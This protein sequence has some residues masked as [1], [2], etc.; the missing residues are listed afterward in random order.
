MRRTLT[1]FSPRTAAVSGLIF[2]LLL[3]LFFTPAYGQYFGRNKVQYEKFDYQ[4]LKTEHF[5]IYFYPEEA[6][7]VRVAAQMAE[8]WYK[9]FSRLLSHELRGRQ[10]LIMYASHPQF[11]QTTVLP[12]ILSEGTGGVTESAKRRIILPFG[13]TLADTDHVIG[14]EL[15]HAFQYDMASAVGPR[16]ANAQNGG[17]LERAPLWFIEG[18]AEYFS[19]GPVDSLTAMWMRDMIRKK[20]IPTI[21]DLRNPYKYFPYRYGQALWA[22]IGGRYGDLTVAK[23]MRDVCRGIDYEV[24]LEKTLNIKLDQ[25][26]KDWQEALKKDYN[27]ILAVTQAPAKLGRLVARG[28]ET[29]PYNVAPV[30]SPDGKTF[31]FISSHDLFSIEM[32]MG[33][34]KTGKITRKITKTAVDSHFQSIQ[35]INSAGSWNADGSRFVFGAVSEGKPV[36]AFLDG[37]GR[38]IVD[39]IKFPAL[40]EILNP[41]FAPDGKRIAFSA[42]TGGYTD[43]YLYDLDTKTLQNMTDDAFGDVHPAWSPDGRWVV[44]VTERYSSQLAT[45]GMIIG[46]YDLALLDTATGDIKKFDVLPGARKINPQWASDSKSIFFVSDRNGISNIYRADLGTRAVAMVTNLYTGISGISN[47]SPSISVASRTNDLFYSAYDDGSYSIYSLE[48]KELQVGTPVP[49]APES[50]LAAVL[51]PKDRQGSEILGLIKNAG[52]GLPDSSKFSTAPYKPKLSLDYVIPPTVGVGYDPYYGAYGGGGIAAYWSDMMGWHNLMTMANVSSRLMDSQA[53]V[54][55]QNSKNRVNFGGVI[56]R[57]PLIY[58]NYA[59]SFDG[60]NY[61]EQE[62]LYRQIYYQVGGFANYPFS[63]FSRFELSAG[64]TYI[65]FN[66]VVYTSVYDYYTGQPLVVDERTDLPSPPGIHMGYL[67][68]ALV[69]D[70]SLFGATAPILGQSYRV[71]VSPSFGT[72]NY[73][74]VTADFRKYLVPVKPFTLAFRVMH[75]G[76]YGKGAEDPRLWPMFLGY[77]MLVR[78]YDYGS[79]TA[80]EAT[81]GGFDMNRLFGS[82]VAIANLELRFPLFGLLGLGKGFYGIFPLDVVGFYDMGLAWDNVNKPWF[83][84]GGNPNWKPVTSAGVGVRVNLFGYIVLGVSY[85]KPFDRKDAAG[86]SIPA[87]FQFSFYPGF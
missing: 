72:L 77:E 34:S 27:P 66:N 23:L 20:K 86:K 55:Y 26:S 14:H 33:D 54:A 37:E 2:G 78:G 3:S 13:G 68:A 41:S 1:R 17:G 85:V 38:K 69:Y 65:Q 39:E 64:Y 61:I 56:Q 70:S 22:Y 36:L 4:V 57:M 44:F 81:T 48:P 67:G 84:S 62:I 83:V 40:G 19:I 12:D 63:P 45:N 46:T 18:L 76:R 5:D 59:A 53:L 79:F 10:P 28:T 32:F 52:Y 25:L 11:E 80:E 24:A 21:K 82:K 75:Y 47:L 31:I 15:V 50:G 6:A 29:D 87:Y 8:R 74:N 16:A 9:R 58:G 71:E 51:P 30:V 7:A 42:L 35:F 60:A 49:D 73:Y 43:I